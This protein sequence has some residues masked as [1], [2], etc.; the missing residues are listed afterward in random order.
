[1]E[2]GAMLTLLF[3][4]G[5]LFMPADTTLAAAARELKQSQLLIDRRTSKTVRMLRW[6]TACGMPILVVDDS[7]DPRMASKVQPDAANRLSMR[8]AKP[9]M[10]GEF[11]QRD[12]TRKPGITFG[13]GTPPASPR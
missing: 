6:P 2:G 9:P 4:A 3:V 11:D 5:Q 8:I 13:P 10:C 1:M 7:L 12:R